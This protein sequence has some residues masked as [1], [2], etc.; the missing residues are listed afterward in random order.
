[1]NKKEYAHSLCGY[2]TAMTV[3][4]VAEVLRVSTKTV[5]KIINDGL[6]PAAKV[7][8]EKRILKTALVDFLRRR[9]L[10]STNPKCVVNENTSDNV[11]TCVPSYS[12]VRGRGSKHLVKMM[13]G[14]NKNE[15]DTCCKYTD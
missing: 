6:L 15:S 14:A 11:W 3:K 9:E 13:K 2:Q 12:I 4:E 7:G 1:M 5:Y 8:R 10:Q